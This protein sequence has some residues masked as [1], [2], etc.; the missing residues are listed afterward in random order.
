MLSNRKEMKM[1]VV[2]NTTRLMHYFARYDEHPVMPGEE[3]HTYGTLEDAVEQQVSLHFENGHSPETAV[4]YELV[5]VSIKE[6]MP[7]FEAKVKEEKE[8]NE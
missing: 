8:N 4:V 6:V 1:Y 2:V 3:P 5:P 7:I